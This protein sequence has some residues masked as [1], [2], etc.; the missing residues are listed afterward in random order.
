[1]YCTPNLYVG[2]IGALAF[3]GAALSCFF[4]PQLGDKYGR[5]FVWAVTVALQIPL[6][7]GANFTSYI[8]V[9]YVMCFY[10]GMGLIGRFACG[11]VLLTESFPKKYQ[12]IV[13]TVSMVGD[14]AATLWITLLLRY[15][16]NDA[17]NMVWIGFGFNILATTMSFFLVDSPSWYVSVGKKDEAIKALQYMAKI[18]GV[19]DFEVTD[20]KEEKFE[21]LDP[22]EEKKK[23]TAQTDP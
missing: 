9:V 18:N 16:S 6:Y 15:V 19:T 10:L 14:A 5:H 11:F 7:I 23:E 17:N 2:F 21:T 20:L 12:A 22:E 3:G 8:G 1:M 13:G 4:V